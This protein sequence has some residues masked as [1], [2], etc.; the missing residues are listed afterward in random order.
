MNN[1]GAV[2]TVWKNGPQRISTL[3][4]IRKAIYNDSFIISL[5]EYALIVFPIVFA[6]FNGIYWLSVLHGIS[7]F[8]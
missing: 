5:D 4:R 7:L 2:E 1:G 6:A 8:E 3:E